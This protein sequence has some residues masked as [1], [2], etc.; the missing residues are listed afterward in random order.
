M[1]RHTLPGWLACTVLGAAMP[2]AL[3]IGGDSAVQTWTFTFGGDDSG[4]GTATVDG[5]GAIQGS[6][7]SSR[8]DMDLTLIG[9]IDADGALSLV[10]TPTGSASTG[11]EFKGQVSGQKAAG[12]W[13]NDDAGLSGTWTA[14]QGGKPA[15]SAHQVHCKVD[16]EEFDATP[17]IVADAMIP[18]KGDQWLF[19]IIAGRGVGVGAH[20]DR[21][22]VQLNAARVKGPGSYPMS[23]EPGWRSNGIAMG[24]EFKIERGTL[25]LSTYNPRGDSRA[26]G[27]FEFDGGGHHGQCS[28]SVH[29]NVQDMARLMGRPSQ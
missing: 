20:G 14:I 4:I 15:G 6:G 18:V 19:R 1:N 5:Q 13:R 29:V 25:N 23:I 24:R 17:P 2:C 26:A 7:H 8:F 12:S 22:Q 10:A 3:A 27:S 9:Q 21:T 11:A 28:F 16:G